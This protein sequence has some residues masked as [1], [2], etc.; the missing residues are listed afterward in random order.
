MSEESSDVAIETIFILPRNQFYTGYKIN[1]GILHTIKRDKAFEYLKQFVS[2]KNYVK[3][4]ELLNRFLPILILVK[5]DR[6]VELKKSRN[7]EEYYHKQLE[8][9]IYGSLTK[10]SFE[11]KEEKV[12]NDALL[13]KVLKKVLK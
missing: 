7:D 11:I 4:S 9:E 1:E 5:E 13:D 3:L 6:I 2:N 12:S 10:G 8:S